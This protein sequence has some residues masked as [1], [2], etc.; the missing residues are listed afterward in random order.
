M[1]Q[2]IAIGAPAGGDTGLPAGTATN[3]IWNSADKSANLTL[4]NSDRTAVS[5]S[6]ISGVRMTSAI[7]DA[8]AT[9]WELVAD[10]KGPATDQIWFAGMVAAA[11]NLTTLGGGAFH[12]ADA[13]VVLT[14]QKA[15]MNTVSAGTILN[16]DQF[17]IA[18]GNTFQFVRSGQYMWIARAPYLS[19]L[20]AVQIAAGTGA[21]YSG[22]SGDLFP[23]LRVTNDATNPQ[24][25]IPTLTGFNAPPG[26]VIG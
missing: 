15:G 16:A 12:L 7:T 14:V 22:L 26:C 20:T 17:A 19:G 1:L 8:T 2:S 11:T 21:T 13:E 18:N 25:T 4:S 10:E 5:S 24:W 9:Y 3:R 6:G 23:Y